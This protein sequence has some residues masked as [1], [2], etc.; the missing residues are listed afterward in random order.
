MNPSNASISGRRRIRPNSRTFCIFAPINHDSMATAYVSLNNASIYQGD[1]LVL[2]HVDFSVQPGE[3]VYIIGRVGTGKSSLVKTLTGELPLITGEG[4]V[5]E[6]ELHNL[7]RR[8]IPLLR[9]SMG[10]VFQDFQLLY[11]RSVYENLAFVLKATG[12]TRKAE[13]D[14]RIDEV[15][16]QVGLRNKGYKMPN[17]ISGGEQQRVAIA[18]A[19]LNKP[20]LILADEPTGNLDPESMNEI[21]NLFVDISRQGTAVIIVTHNYSV[22]KRFPART[23]KCDKGQIA[24]LEHEISEIDFHDLMEGDFSH[25][26]TR[27]VPLEIL[28]SEYA[29][30]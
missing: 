24:Q 10:V 21:M 13:M 19:L 3:M 28:N 29:E 8:Q 2:V 1:H 15:L 4:H 25:V 7:R 18:R 14:A 30:N 5:G 23:Y 16:H 22:L 6:F 17:Q 20:G 11:D 26:A 9:R 12:W 27:P